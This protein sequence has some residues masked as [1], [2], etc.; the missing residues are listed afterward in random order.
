MI[1]RQE[2][3]VLVSNLEVYEENLGLAL[4][5]ERLGAVVL[6]SER[7][8]TDKVLL[9]AAQQQ[10][11]ATADLKSADPN[12]PVINEAAVLDA[13]RGASEREVVRLTQVLQRTL[14]GLQDQ[15]A[16]P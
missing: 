2:A 16:I 9:D 6:D 13:I 8:T 12:K 11:I 4:S 3:D 15:I 10:M 7:A 14:A 1:L 5:Y